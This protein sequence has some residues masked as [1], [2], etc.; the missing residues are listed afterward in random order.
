MCQVTNFFQM[1]S[2]QIINKH[3]GSNDK[4]FNNYT[5]HIFLL[6]FTVKPTMPTYEFI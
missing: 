1:S 3:I 6:M 4:I 5:F 2:D